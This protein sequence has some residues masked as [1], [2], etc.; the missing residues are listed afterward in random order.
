[1]L[2]ASLDANVIVP[3]VPCDFLLTA[4]DHGLYEPIVSTTVIDEI[5]RALAVDFP[6]LELAAVRRRV[7]AMRSVLADQTVDGSAV[8][9]P[10]TVN[11]K[12]RHI[13]GGAL[14][15]E[16]HL[17]VTNDRRLRG[18]IADAGLEVCA[19]DL[20]TFARRLWESSPGAVA[21]VVDDL[22]RKRRRRPVTKA[23]MWDAIGEH[24]PSLPALQVTKC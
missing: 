22:V 4:F 10:G 21:K 18:E 6:H 1:M 12:D 19:V 16:S 2:V 20:D 15:A 23:E 3:I 24:M 17:I 14:E 5:E 7:A 13:V 8:D 11:E 9:V